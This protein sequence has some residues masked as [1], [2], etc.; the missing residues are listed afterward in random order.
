MS[1]LFSVIELT[2]DNGMSV[3]DIVNCT[4][5]DT[6]D[7][8]GLDVFVDL[9]EEYPE[10]NE[11]EVNRSTYLWGAGESDYANEEEL[12]YIKQR[13]DRFFQR[14][15]VDLIGTQ[16]FIANNYLFASEEENNFEMEM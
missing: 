5:C 8:Q 11:V 7:M 12:T 3:S 2:A 4:P 14:D 16:N 10:I 9:L 15:D 6:D 1:V 13:G